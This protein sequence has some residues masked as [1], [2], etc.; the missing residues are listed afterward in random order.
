MSEAIVCNNTHVKKILF[1]MTHESTKL[2]WDDD[3]NDE[4][5]HDSYHDSYDDTYRDTYSDTSYSD[6]W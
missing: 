6:N 2:S 1:Q 3:Y 5:Y 4:T